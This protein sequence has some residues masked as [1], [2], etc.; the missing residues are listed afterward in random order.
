[1]SSGARIR[2]AIGVALA[3]S[4]VGAYWLAYE[5]GAMAIILDGYALRQWVLGLG[6]AGPLAVVGLMILAILVSPIPSAPVALA[7]GALYGHGW[8]TAYIALGAELGAL[9]AF[10]IARL[11]GRDALHHWFGGRL[12]R[13][14]LGSQGAL[15]TIVFVSRLLP[16]ISFDV[17]SY[18][19]GFTVLAW[20]RFALATLAGILP[21][22]FLLAHFGGEMASGEL[23]RILYAALLLG[24]LTAVPLGIHYLRQRR[25][26]DPT[27]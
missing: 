8:G 21:T 18:A 15:M 11:L 10:G 13:T 12:P 26:D 20:W 7:A 9:A 5:S 3:L 23:E 16:F 2:L 24:L 6:L 17:V 27:G 25:R 19:A 4:I 22:S 1:M 14:R